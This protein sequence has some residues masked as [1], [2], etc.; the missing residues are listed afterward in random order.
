[1]TTIDVSTPEARQDILDGSWTIDTDGRL[2]YA[3]DALEATFARID[4]LERER[5]EATRLAF[6]LAFVY[7]QGIGRDPTPAEEALFHEVHRL[8][9]TPYT[10]GW[11]EDYPSWHS[12]ATSPRNSWNTEAPKATQSSTVPEAPDC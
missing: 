2:S 12:P 10:D 9:G 11:E 4:E 7:Q 3:R 1:M 6:T 5:Q 8:D